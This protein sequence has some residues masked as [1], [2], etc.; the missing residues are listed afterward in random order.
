MLQQFRDGIRA[1]LQS[2]D[3]PAPLNA[4]ALDHVRLVLDEARAAIGAALHG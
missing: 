3:P 1:D 2:Q 4:V